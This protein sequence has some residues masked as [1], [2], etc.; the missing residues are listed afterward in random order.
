MGKIIKRL[1]A[2]VANQIAAG[3]VVQRPSSALKELLENAVDSGADKIEVFLGDGGKQLIQVVDNGQGID[4]EDLPL[5]IERHATSKLTSAEDL[6]RLQTKG[7]RGE[8]LASIASIAQLRIQSKTVEAEEGYV[9]SVQGS[10]SMEIQLTPSSQGTIVT[11]QH[12]FYNIPAR[13]QFLKSATVELKH[14]LDEFHRLV[15]VHPEISFVLH[16]NSEVLFQL[17]QAPIKQRITQ[18]FGQK[19]AEKLVPIS[20]QTPLVG[21][22]GF[23]LKPDMA[24]KSRGMQYFFVNDRFI[25]SG[26]LHH[27]VLQAFEGLVNPGV[28]P[29]YF[30]YLQVDPARLDVNIHPTKTEVKFDDEQGIY[31]I[32]RSAVKHSLGQF[33]VAPILD[34]DKD[35]NLDTPYAYQSKNPVYPKIEVDRNF[36]PFNEHTPAYKSKPSQTQWETLYSL[37]DDPHRQTMAHFESQQTSLEGWEQETKTAFT[38][39]QWEKKYIVT[40]HQSALLVIHQSRAHQRIVYERLLAQMTMEKAGSQ[41]LLFP[42]TLGLSIAQQ[43]ILASM[44]GDL[45][46]IGF[47]FDEQSIDQV[48]GIPM[49]VLPQDAAHVLIQ[50]V[51]D[52]ESIEHTGFSTVDRMAQL[53]SKSMAINTGKFLTVEEQLGLINDL[54]SCKEPEFSPDRK[55]VIVSITAEELLKK[56]S[57]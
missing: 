10:S 44:R 55:P 39:F 33:Q 5:S 34:F 8:A 48:L 1:E 56:F 42:L 21:I 57:L 17:P 14:C 32:L 3:E 28:H 50:L 13:R 9:L 40:K 25:K 45:Q 38:S 2:H 24:K 49:D 23:I 29:G 26:F 7:F 47:E 4:R 15:L 19:Y 41:T 43:S 31:A 54:F 53:M 18:V 30:I 16:H 46:A 11:V 6:F 22:S 20:E 51:D 35:P 37:G 36:N 27:A 12:L 52:L